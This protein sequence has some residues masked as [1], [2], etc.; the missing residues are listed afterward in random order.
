[1]TLCNQASS[2]TQG[3]SASPICR[4]EH[5]K[6]KPI[7]RERESGSG[8]HQ[9]V[10]FTQRISVISPHL[11]PGQL[12]PLLAQV[13]LLYAGLSTSLPQ[14]AFLAV[15]GKHRLHRQTR[16][17]GASTARG[18]G[19]PGFSR[20]LWDESDMQLPWSSCTVFTF[21]AALFV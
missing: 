12:R 5:S 2:H 8:T 10:Q 14:V 7:T 13:A 17:E 11:T 19:D 20:S 16:H 9:Q 21:V 1:M 4:K 3:S 15:F 6:T 18:R